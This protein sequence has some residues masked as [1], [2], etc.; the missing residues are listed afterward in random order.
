MVRFI[1]LS[2]FW[3]FST[4]VLA[5]G[6]APPEVKSGPAYVVGGVGIDQREVL[7][8][9]YGHYSLR[10]EVAEKGGAYTADVQII[11]TDQRGRS[12]M[13]VFMDGPVLLVDLP[14]GLY[15]VEGRQ[16]SRQQSR[17][18]TVN[19]GRQTKTTLIFPPYR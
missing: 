13:E 2:A 19:A 15:N 10:V 5:A 8:K 7:N 17:A 3:M 14:P 16:Y 12:V 9:Q 1:L 18:V 11:I 6:L 4:S